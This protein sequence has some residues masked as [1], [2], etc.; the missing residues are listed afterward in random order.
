MSQE[1]NTLELAKIYESQGYLQDALEM[2][3][4]LAKKSGEKDGQEGDPEID[5]GLDRMES[6]MENQPETIPEP[7]VPVS[8]KK[9]HH[10]MEQWL[11]LMVLQ[12]RFNL[13]KQV[14]LRF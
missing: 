3:Q 7:F 9:I 4:A 6:A 12:K 1:F 2:Y 5:A 13:M 14:K 11:M 8:E 10:I